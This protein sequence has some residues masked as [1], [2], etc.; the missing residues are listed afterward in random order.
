MKH[1]VTVSYLNM[2]PGAKVRQ[3]RMMSYSPPDH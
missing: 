3:Q 2:S 1:T